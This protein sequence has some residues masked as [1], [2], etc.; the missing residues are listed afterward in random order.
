LIGCEG[1]EERNEQTPIEAT[2][3][4]SASP[5]PDFNHQLDFC[6]T[7]QPGDT[8]SLSYTKTRSD[9][10]FGRSETRIDIEVVEE[11]SNGFLLHWTYEEFELTGLP[12]DDPYEFLENEA[13]EF[14]KVLTELAEI[15]VAIETEPAPFLRTVR[16]L[17]DHA[18]SSLA[19]YSR[20]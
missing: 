18:A 7:W 10:P 2:V 12:V 8:T 3:T 17:A 20:S 13:P 14:S 16:F 4:S 6:P 15:P 1:E 11:T 5:L 9:R 19:V